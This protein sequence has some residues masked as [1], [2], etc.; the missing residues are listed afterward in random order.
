M[1]NRERGR[2]TKKKK[3]MRGEEKG[4]GRRGDERRGER[5]RERT[6]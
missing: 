4:M 3:A 6:R 5:E 2:K 1:S